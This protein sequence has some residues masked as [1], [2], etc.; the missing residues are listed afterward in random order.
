[1]DVDDNMG[2]DDNME[3][4]DN[5]ELVDIK[6]FLNFAI[7]FLIH[8]EDNKTWIKY[9]GVGFI[10]TCSYTSV[11]IGLIIIIFEMNHITNAEMLTNFLLEKDFT[12]NQFIYMINETIG[13]FM[14]IIEVCP[15]VGVN[16]G[17]K[18]LIQKE[19][20]DQRNSGNIIKAISGGHELMP[21][22]NIISFTGRGFGICQTFHH[23]TI[24]I[25]NQEFHVIDS[26][27][28][29][30]EVCRPLSI[31]T[32][33]LEEG[34]E[35]I[36]KIS[37]FNAISPET[38]FYFKKLF[39]PPPEFEID[40]VEQGLNLTAYKVNIDYVASVFRIYESIVSEHKEK[41]LPDPESHF[42]G[43]TRKHHKRTRKHHKKHRKSKK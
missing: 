11:G 39:I 10:E 23:S 41:G 9:G 32:Y 24:Y 8:C 26:W 43:K 37:V 13:N 5:T 28:S 33:S 19:I 12:L 18:G 30:N 2:L 42:G 3:L 31:R 16:N 29:S 21:G 35:A 25:R 6:P 14:D 20:I 7:Q 38:L 27:R 36:D 40:F 22:V 15:V 4:V 17:I 1:M 34:R